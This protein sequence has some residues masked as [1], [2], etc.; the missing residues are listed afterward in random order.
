MKIK[1]NSNRVTAGAIIFVFVPLAVIATFCGYVLL[2]PFV[3]IK[4][5]Q[6]YQLTGECFPDDCQKENAMWYLNLKELD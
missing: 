5:I 4:C 6:N 3:T 2:T 1:L